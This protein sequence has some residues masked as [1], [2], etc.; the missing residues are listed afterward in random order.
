MPGPSTPASFQRPD[1]G[2]AFEEFDLMSAASGFVGLRAMP[3]T[4]VGLQTASFS[5]IPLEHLLN[6]SRNLNR[7]PG[8]G[9]ARQEYEFEQD[10]YATDEIGAEEVLD[11]RERAIYGYTGIRFDQISADRAVSALMRHIENAIATTLQDATTYAAQTTAVGTEW[12]TVASA[13]PRADVLA[14]RERFR[15]RVGFYPNTLVLSSKV[16]NN[17]IQCAEITDLI[18]Y[19]GYNDGSGQNYDPLM[20]DEQLLAKLFKVQSVVIAGGGAVRNSANAGLA[21]SPTDIWDDEY[22]SLLQAPNTDDL[23]E[24]CFGRTMTF[25]DLVVEQYRDESKRS[26]IL[27]A[28]QDFDVKPI[29]GEALEILSNV[30]A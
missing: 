12:S 11:D 22:V 16:H 21:A 17:L 27:R 5:K 15:A 9:Y 19:G 2:L 28:R 26:D 1:L 20:V 13:T 18:K 23:R 3:L 29:Y 10:N 4:R 6:D 24:V 14:A 25:E 30:T 7:A 8:G